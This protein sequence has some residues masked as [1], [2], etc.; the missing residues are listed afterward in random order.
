MMTSFPSKSDLIRE[1]Q[2]IIDHPDADNAD[3][4]AAIR[5][6]SEMMGYYAAERKEVTLTVTRSNGQRRALTDD[7]LGRLLGDDVLD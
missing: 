3:R 7:E 2:G 5:L 1:L 6:I 4:I